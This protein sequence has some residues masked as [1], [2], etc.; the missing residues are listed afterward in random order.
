ML[1]GVSPWSSRF[2]HQP[3]KAV[4][5]KT[6]GMHFILEGKNPRNSPGPPGFTNPHPSLL[7]PCFARSLL[8]SWGWSLLHV[9]LGCSGGLV[10]SRWLSQAPIQAEM[11]NR[12]QWKIGPHGRY[13][14]Q[15]NWPSCSV[16]FWLM[17]VWMRAF[18]TRFRLE[19]QFGKSLW[20]CVCVHVGNFL[21]GLVVKN[22][23]VS[24]GNTGSIPGPGRSHMLWGSWAYAP[25]QEKPLQWEARTPQ[26]N[27][28]SCSPQLEKAPAQQWRSSAAKSKIIL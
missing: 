20:L 27:S 14:A 2:H 22:P 5:K 7:P 21:G 25:Q 19:M 15:L 16:A 9:F 6:Q 10:T 8:T 1:V 4:I 24:A 11:P 18:K 26:L 17:W 12:L 13:C 28:S 3:S 23:P